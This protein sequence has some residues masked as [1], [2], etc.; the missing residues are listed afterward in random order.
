MLPW[1]VGIYESQLE[2]MDQEFAKLCEEY[3]PFLGPQLVMTKP[4]LM[5]V[6]PVERNIPVN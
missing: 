6:I 5:Q 3:S 2:C 1:L 4:Q